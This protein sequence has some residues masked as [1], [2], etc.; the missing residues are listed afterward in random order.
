[1]NIEVL[2]FYEG[3]RALNQSLVDRMSLVV[4]V[5]LPTADVMLERVMRVTGA[6]DECEVIKMVGVANKLATYC[7]ENHITDGCVGMRSLIDW[8]MSAEITE[9]PY[10][11]AL[12]TI[13]SKATVDEDERRN[14]IETIL[15]EVYPNPEE[16][17]A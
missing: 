16:V 8:V 3:C 7:K 6:T 12:T 2:V 1:M 4:D 14:L 5:S 15:E 11:S 17:A 13:I 9:N 10:E